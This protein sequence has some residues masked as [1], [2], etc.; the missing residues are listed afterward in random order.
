MADPDDTIRIPRPG[1]I[2][3]RPK[4]ARKKGRL[5][6]IV[7]ALAA[8]VLV[9]AAGASGVFWLT[10]RPAASSVPVAPAP[11]EAPPPAMQASAPAPTPAG[12]PALTE[13][14]ILARSPGKTEAYRFAPQPEIV[15]I[16]FA[17]YAEQAKMLNRV[18]AL[19]EK[20]GFPRD[21]IMEIGELEKRIRT[22]GGTFDT[23]YYGHDYA[24]A[25]VL[26]FLDLLDKSG[27]PATD[28]ETALRRMTADWGWQPGT[29]GALITLVQDDGT[30]IVD[31]AGRATI[32]RHELSHGFYFTSPDYARYAR[33]FWRETLSDG[34][35]TR[36][37]LFLANDG[38]DTTLSDL[39]INETQAYLMHTA[40]PKFFSAKAVGI[41]PARLDI[42]RGLFLT[43]MPPGW[44]RD[45]TTVPVRVPRR[46]QGRLVRRR[47][48]LADRRAP[49]AAA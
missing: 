37:R 46:R 34:E 14:A 10:G 39:V 43:G 8:L 29:N 13:A 23:F 32:L 25:T 4:L 49:L 28:G 16:V 11:S 47:R 24:A 9:G 5:L 6:G 18:A 30:T 40:D 45:C 20:A 35:R 19:V 3:P 2:P 26:R 21:R 27:L 31:A 17:S 22:D 7:A 41:D 33:D 36:F 38:Y 15:V 12:L 44:L 48:M 42:L 1:E